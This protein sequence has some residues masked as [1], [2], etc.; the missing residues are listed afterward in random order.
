MPEIT[1]LLRDPKT[2]IAVV[3]ATD[4]P[5][6]Y[7]NRIF[8]DL[9]RKGF[10]VFPVNPKRDTVEGVEAYPSVADLPEAPTIVDFVVPPRFTL[11]GLKQCLE[12]GLMN[13]WIQPGAEDEAVLDFL[14]ANGFNYLANACIMVQSPA[15]A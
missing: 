6:K 12:L 10:R 4:D 5:A 13:V 8:R 3:G 15:H 11:H 2:T 14:E 1:E 9:T 7:G